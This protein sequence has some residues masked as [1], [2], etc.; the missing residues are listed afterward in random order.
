[1]SALNLFSIFVAGMDATGFLV[2][3]RDR[4]RGWAAFFLAISVWCAAA[5][6]FL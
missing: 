2:A 5:G 6:V 3:Y 4:D 1:M